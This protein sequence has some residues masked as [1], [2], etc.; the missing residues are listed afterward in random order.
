MSIAIRE[1]KIEC[2][3]L[4]IVLV[5]ALWVGLLGH[6]VPTNFHIPHSGPWLK[7]NTHRP[8]ASFQASHEE[9]SLRKYRRY[10]QALWKFLHN[11]S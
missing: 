2:F 6:A 5:D 8:L 4:P 7:Q 10:R 1:Q 11:Q 3:H 9:E